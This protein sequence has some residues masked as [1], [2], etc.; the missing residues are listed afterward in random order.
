MVTIKSLSEKL[1]VRSDMV[2]GEPS[3]ATAFVTPRNREAH[4]LLRE[5]VYSSGDWGSIVVNDV[6]ISTSQLSSL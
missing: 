1:E 6:I 5:S 3:G 2:A 4:C